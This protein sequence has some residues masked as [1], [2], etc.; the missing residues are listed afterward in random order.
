[1]KLISIAIVSL[2]CLLSCSETAPNEDH[3]KNITGDWRGV[4]WK[5]DGVK[6]QGNARGLIMRFDGSG[7]FM[8]DI[9]QEPLKGAYKI[10]GD[11]LELT[12]LNGEALELDIEKLSMDSMF[13]NTDDRGVEEQMVFIRKYKRDNPVK[14]SE[15]PVQLRNEKEK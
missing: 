2:L 9:G 6:A 8:A 14:S 4:A 3:L 13:L 11:E 12:L 15:L 1:M 7:R 10:S 5:K